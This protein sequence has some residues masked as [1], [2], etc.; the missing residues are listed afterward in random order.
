MAWALT[1]EGWTPVTFVIL[2]DWTVHIPPLEN[3]FSP[4]RHRHQCRPTY[5]GYYITVNVA[6]TIKLFIRYFSLEHNLKEFTYVRMVG[7]KLDEG[8]R[9]STPPCSTEM[10][11]IEHENIN[12]IEQC[13]NTLN[14]QRTN[15]RFRKFIVTDVVLTQ[16]RLCVG[17]Y[18][19]YA[20]GSRHWAGIITFFT[21]DS[22]YHHY[23]TKHAHSHILMFY[24]LKR[25]SQQISDPCNFFPMICLRKSN[26]CV[27][28]TI[29]RRN[30]VIPVIT[31]CSH[32]TV[33][34]CSLLPTIYQ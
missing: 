24:F 31:R 34:C 12:L 27:K 5:N 30:E 16:R 4:L 15:V 18:V 25:R 21:A 26:L 19:C 9:L 17:V 8:Q 2:D 28:D 1:S 22:N 13:H 33:H 6:D 23:N 10:P 32:H 29:R 14:T 11:E 3:T 20:T 7:D